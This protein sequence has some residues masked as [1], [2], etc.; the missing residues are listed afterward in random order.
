[1]LDA[2]PFPMG[3][4][5]AKTGKRALKPFDKNNPPSDGEGGGSEWRTLY[6]KASDDAIDLLTILMK[7]DPSKRITAADGLTH[8]YCIQ[9]HD[10]ETEVMATNE[11]AIPIHDNKKLSTQKYRELLYE[12]LSKKKASA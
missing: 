10:K 8:P 11:V 7:Y 9:F 5:D 6:P 3:E 2:M 12:D 4:L 1:M